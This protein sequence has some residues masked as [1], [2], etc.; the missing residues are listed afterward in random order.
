MEIS[1]LRYFVA[2]ARLENINAAAR[3]SGASLSSLT[4]AIKRLE[5]ELATTLFSSANKRIQLTDS[6][7]QLFELALDLIEREENARN[8]MSGS[9]DQLKIRVCGE[10]VLLTRSVQWLEENLLKRPTQKS[11]VLTSR[12]SDAVLAAIE[13][14]ESHLGLVTVPPPKSFKSRKLFH[15][16]FRTYVGRGHPLFKQ[17]NAGIKIKVQ[18]LLT[19]DFVSVSAQIFGRVSQLQSADGWRD[20]KFPRKVKYLVD[21]LLSVQELVSSGRAIGYLPD[22]FA[23]EWK[24]AVL[25]VIGCP[26][27]CDYDAYLIARQPIAFGWINQLFD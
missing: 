9:F 16:K 24:L 2:V 17:A 23:Q 20:D 22:F 15:T 14:G 12:G 27:V 13:R 25:D 3:E 1:Q 7:R 19:H 10:D 11:F 26:Y 18:D 8:L 4:H 21:N 6:G 5:A